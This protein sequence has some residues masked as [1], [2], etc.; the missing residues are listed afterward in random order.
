M[1]FCLLPYL[2]L[3]FVIVVVVD[4]TVFVSGPFQQQDIDKIIWRNVEFFISSR[5]EIVHYALVLP[6]T[7]MT[8]G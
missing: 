7:I 8:V 3:V 1:I 5:N 4:N 6:C 2:Q